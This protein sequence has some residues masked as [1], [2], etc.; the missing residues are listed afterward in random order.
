MNYRIYGLVLI[1]C[2]GSSENKKKIGSVF[3][4]RKKKKKKKKKR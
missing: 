3:N 1:S 2:V 4:A